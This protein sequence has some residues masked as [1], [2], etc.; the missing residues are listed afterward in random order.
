MIYLI[1]ASLIWGFSFGI[2]KDSL[3]TLDSNFVAFMRLFLSFLIF[4]PF[5]DFK[6][7]NS[8]KLKAIAVGVVQYGIMYTAYIYSYQFLAAY[9]VAL[10]TIFTPIYVSIIGNL[11]KKTFKISD[12]LFAIITVI[13]TGVIVFKSPDKSN[14]I[15]GFILVQV[16][17]V[18][19]ALG[20]ILYRRLMSSEEHVHDYRIIG[21]LFL[22]GVLVT[23]IMTPISANIAD[24]Q[25]ST[26]QFLALLY[27]GIVASGIAF[28]IWNY[29]CRKVQ[30]G[31]LS[32]FQN[33][34]IPTAIAISLIFFGEEANIT[35]LI[36]G[37]S[38]IFT[39]IVTNE[40]IN[41]NKKLT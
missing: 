6:L 35:S 28:F 23:A 20:Q 16:A 32:I 14:L 12:L 33:L 13:G 38:I 41:K 7:N 22:G 30:I 5:L 24:L 8:I 2:I 3:T 27:L 26:E 31:T 17:N 25:I 40:L 37:S 21:Y 10:F 18:C 29:G 1:I 19:F 39:A 15:T 34:K 36:I 4:I 11:G 9:E